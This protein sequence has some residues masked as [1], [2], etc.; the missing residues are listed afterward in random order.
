MIYIIKI[1]MA[2]KYL[3]D[4]TSVHSSLANFSFLSHTLSY[5][6]S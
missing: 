6:Y 3:E 1:T 2:A 5:I 4:T